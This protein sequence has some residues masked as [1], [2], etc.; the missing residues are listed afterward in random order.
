MA[1]FPASITQRNSPSARTPV[2]ALNR[3]IPAEHVGKTLRRPTGTPGLG[4]DEAGHG[5]ALKVPRAAW[6]LE[7]AIP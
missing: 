2:V 3:S 1:R 6:I 5:N 4:I 7:F